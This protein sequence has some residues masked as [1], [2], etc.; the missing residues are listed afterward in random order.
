[1]AAERHGH[2][3]GDAST[4]PIAN[5]GAAQIAYEQP[6]APGNGRVRA[7]RR[8]VTARIPLYLLGAGILYLFYPGSFWLPFLLMP[9]ALDL[10]FVNLDK[11]LKGRVT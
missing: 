7:L 2:P 11:W 3:L 6:A 5:S 9:A 4:H 8:I 10:A 1:M